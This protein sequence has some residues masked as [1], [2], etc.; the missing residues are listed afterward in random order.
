M[1]TI[2]QVSCLFASSFSF[3]FVTQTQLVISIFFFFPFF[4]FRY[5]LDIVFDCVNVIFRHLAISIPGIFLFSELFFDRLTSEPNNIK[6][7]Q[8]VTATAN[9]HL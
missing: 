1:A 4:P 8:T 2:L 6:S 9:V 3:S 5:L 7:I